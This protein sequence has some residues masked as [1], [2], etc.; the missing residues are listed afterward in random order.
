MMAMRKFED[1]EIDTA[2]ASIMRDRNK[3]F[4][5]GDHVRR[6]RKELHE[7]HS[8]PNPISNSIPKQKWKTKLQRNP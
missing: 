2:R 5:Q 6:I 4:V 1:A 7:V 3:L 8:G